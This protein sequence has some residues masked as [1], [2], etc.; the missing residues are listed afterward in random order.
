MG[1]EHLTYA[2]LEDSTN[3]LA[4]ALAEHGC[5]RGDRV[6][7]LVPKSLQAIVGIVGTLKADAIYVPLDP[8]NPV[9]R[10][11]KMI[12]AC[13]PRCILVAGAAVSVLDDILADNPLPAVQ[14]GS[15]GP[16]RQAA[17]RF[18]ANFCLADLR[19][20]PAAPPPVRNTERDAAYLL[21]TSGSTGEPKAVVITHSNVARFL[22]WAIPY[23]R[24]GSSDRIS[25]HSPLHFDLSVFDLFGALAAGAELHLV[26]PELNLTPA[27]IAD[28]IR[29]AELT[30]WFS[31]PAVLNFMAKADVV[32]SGDFPTLRRVLWCGE[33]LPTPTLLH[34]MKRLPHVSF[35]NL[36]G[37]TEATIA[38]SYYTVTQ[39]PKDERQPIPIG[40]SCEGEELLVLNPDLEPVRPGETGDIYIRGVGLSPGYWRDPESTRLA[41]LPH[42]RDPLER[43]YKTGDLG[44]VGEDGLIYFSGRTDSQ[45][46]SRG[47]RIE[48]GEIEAALNAI[49]YLL[50]SAVVAVPSSGFEGSI[51]CCAYTVA[52]GSAVTPVVLRRDLA[53]AVPS[54]MLP[55]RWLALDRLPKN[56]NGKIDR[57]RL[58]NM[59]ENQPGLTRGPTSSPA[60]TKGVPHAGAA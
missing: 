29:S 32:R 37:P 1:H 47:Y 57:P 24:L 41:F 4:W 50:E 10:L 39:C 18:E 34:W 5:R 56:G 30:Q 49:G 20:Y 14:F 12:A 23:F 33:V 35:T 3:R 17:N 21:F 45:I 8:S 59:F 31:V 48:L 19:D 40:V 2:Q 46:K 16:Q 28:F 27:R 15:L 26:P 60:S 7:L 55:S 25:G 22:E 58:R 43:I 51:I 9:Q 36:Y 38:S 11:R 42:P 44:K 6:C 13:E 52:P 54:Y 53:N